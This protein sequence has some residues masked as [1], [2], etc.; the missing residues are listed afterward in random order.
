MNVNEFSSLISGISITRIQQGG[1]TMNE[2]ARMV[3]SYKPKDGTS[4]KHMKEN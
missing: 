4:F 3:L 2:D 1:A